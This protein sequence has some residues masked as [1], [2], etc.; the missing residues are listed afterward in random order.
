MKKGKLRREVVTVKT[1]KRPNIAAGERK[2]VGLCE[3][4]SESAMLGQTSGQPVCAS[5]QSLIIRDVRG[6]KA[7]CTWKMLE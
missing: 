7:T 4:G 3:G 6:R 2:D 5:A 1:K